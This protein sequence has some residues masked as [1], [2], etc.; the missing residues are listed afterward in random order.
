MPVFFPLLVI[1]RVQDTDILYTQC[2]EIEINTKLLQVELRSKLRNTFAR[3]P[4]TSFR[5][6]DYMLVTLPSR[7]ST[8]S[9]V[10]VTTFHL[11]SMQ[12]IVNDHPHWLQTSLHLNSHCGL[13]E[14]F[15]T[16]LEIA[17]SVF[18]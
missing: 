14:M 10:E 17:W 16:P 15:L 11:E 7:L 13:I 2:G 12:E 1:L 8:L 4:K 3:L 9:G 18:L 6:L 5:L